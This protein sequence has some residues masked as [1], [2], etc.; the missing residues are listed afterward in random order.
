MAIDANKRRRIVARLWNGVSTSKIVADLKVGH[1][2]VEKIRGQCN[3][4][5]PISAGGRPK[6]S[7]GDS[8]YA[9]FR[10]RA[11]KAHCP[12]CGVEV[13]MPCLACYLRSLPKK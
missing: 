4:A 3:I 5:V 11:K 12:E 6:K 13:A 2:T 8:P 9:L 7:K 1:H 10:S